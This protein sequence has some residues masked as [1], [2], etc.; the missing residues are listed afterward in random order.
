MLFYQEKFGYRFKYEFLF[1]E[2][3]E[4]HIH[5]EIMEIDIVQRDFTPFLVVRKFC[6]IELPLKNSSDTNRLVNTISLL[7]ER[8]LALNCIIKENICKINQFNIDID[9]TYTT[10]PDKGTRI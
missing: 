6:I 2:V 1:S 3:N 4:I 9:K 10:P 7:C 5:E 8:L